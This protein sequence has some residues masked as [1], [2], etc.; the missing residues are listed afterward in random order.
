MKQPGSVLLRRKLHEIFPIHFKKKRIALSKE[1][2]GRGVSVMVWKALVIEIRELDSIK[3][4]TLSTVDA[5]LTLI[6]SSSNFTLT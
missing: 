1:Y 2:V 3:K 5:F 4:L 6:Y